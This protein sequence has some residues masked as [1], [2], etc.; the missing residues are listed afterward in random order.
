MLPPD[1]IV[2]VQPIE[3]PDLFPGIRL[4][5]KRD[6]LLHPAYGGNKWRKLKYNL[7][8]AKESGHDTI[9]TFGGPW[10]NH[11]HATAAACADLGFQSIGIIRGEEPANWSQ[12]LIGARER[13]MRLVFISRAEYAEKDEHFFKAWLHDRFGSFFLIPEGGANYLG[14]QG[15]S[16]IIGY[17]ERTFD[18]IV[19]PAGTGTTAAGLLLASKPEQK[20]L[21]V[22]ALK[23]EDRLTDTILI[24]LGWALGD[25][26]FGEDFREKLTVTH[27]YCC[28]GYA[29]YTP[30]LPGF[31]A[32]LEGQTGLKT[33][34]VYTGKMFF[35]LSQLAKSGHF[36]KD[37]SV[38]AI[39]TGGLQGLAGLREE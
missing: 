7:I 1:P 2:P 14:I 21:A 32:E 4:S 8:K 33:D 22:S 16:E 5:V 37:A 17:E 12:T 27:D 9:L 23:G 38:L 34:Q 15:C 25:P 31:M 3:A 24:S 30:E 28:G 13:G 19:C 20:V 26:S 6:D 10:S 18:L 39:H 35:A 29:K 11:I 36:Q